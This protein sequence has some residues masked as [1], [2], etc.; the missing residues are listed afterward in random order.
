MGGPLLSESL[1]LGN[2][3]FV[4]SGIRGIVIVGISREHNEVACLFCS[5]DETVEHSAPIPRAVNH[6][7][8]SKSVRR[9]RQ[10]DAP[11]QTETLSLLECEEIS[12][13][14]GRADERHRALPGEQVG[15]PSAHSWYGIEREA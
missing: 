9:K 1:C 4:R 12:A 5:P 15:E 13:A 14:G 7:G 8:L 3:R 11:P 10:D 2:D 6:R